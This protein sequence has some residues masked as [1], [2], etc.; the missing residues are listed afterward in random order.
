MSSQA[1][2]MLKDLS[3]QANQDNIA[4]SSAP[5]LTRK[6]LK[7]TFFTGIPEFILCLKPSPQKRLAWVALTR[8]RTSAS[9]ASAKGVGFMPPKR[10]IQGPDRG[11]Q[12]P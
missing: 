8:W 5:P 9:S 10:P 4:G 7:K 11:L 12:R 3:V 6:D 1:M 2:V